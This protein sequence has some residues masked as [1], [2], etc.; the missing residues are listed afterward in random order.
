M[1]RTSLGGTVSR[2]VMS[3][4]RRVA[5]RGPSAADFSR[6]LGYGDTSAEGVVETFRSLCRIEVQVLPLAVPSSA[7]ACS[8]RKEMVAIQPS[9]AFDP[10]MGKIVEEIKD[11]AFGNRS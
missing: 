3:G 8:D 6:F 10:A 5:T 2:D 9:S 7:Q 1:Q 4:F 11:A